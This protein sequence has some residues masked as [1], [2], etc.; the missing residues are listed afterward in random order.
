MAALVYRIRMSR[1]C[2][3]GIKFRPSGSGKSLSRKSKFGIAAAVWLE[4]SK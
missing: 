3:I 2:N 4:A 1:R